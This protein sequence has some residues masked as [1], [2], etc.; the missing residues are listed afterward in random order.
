MTVDLDDGGIHP[1]V[2]QVRLIRS[3]NKKPLENI[4][5]HPVA[6]PLED[7]VPAAEQRGQV[8]PGSAGSRDPQYRLDKPAI[9]RAATAG[10]R[11]LPPA[12]R[13]HFRPLGVGQHISVHRQ[14]KARYLDRK[15]LNLNRPWQACGASGEGGMT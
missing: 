11:L 3:G 5:S 12:M 1:G 4:R 10:V 8:A 9:I 13:L 14:L 2:L 15:K 7:V 6:I